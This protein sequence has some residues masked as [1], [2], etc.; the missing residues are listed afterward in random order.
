MNNQKLFKAVVTDF[1]GT[2]ID[3]NHIKKNAFISA[4]NQINPKAKDQAKKIILK[5]KNISRYEFSK[6]LFH[7]MRKKNIF[8]YKKKFLYKFNHICSH[9]VLKTKHIYGSLSLLRWLNK[10]KIPVFISTSTPEFSIK[11]IISKLGWSSYFKEIY[12]SPNSKNYHINVIHK[13]Y[14]ISKDKI[15]FIGD[16]LIDL[17]TAKKNNCKFIGVGKEIK[18]EIDKYNLNYM[19]FNTCYGIKNY[20]EKKIL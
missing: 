16:G 6:I 3:S 9:K 10:I 4:V 17:Q 20:L 13:N 7:E 5:N 12:G 14:K 11:K 1:D 18:F 15:L 19:S 2:L 8:F